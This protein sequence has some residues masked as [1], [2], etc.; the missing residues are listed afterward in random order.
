MEEKYYFFCDHKEAVVEDP[1]R[2]MEG[3]LL[4]SAVRQEVRCCVLLVVFAY[5]PS[6][7]V[8]S[9]VSHV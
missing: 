7:R 4:M 2:H 6:R 5:F 9:H 3:A 8:Q 1:E